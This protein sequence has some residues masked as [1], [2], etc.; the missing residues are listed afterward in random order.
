[1]EIRVW[2]EN[3]TPYVGDYAVGT[4]YGTRVAE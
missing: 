1:M 4:F 3:D 2:L